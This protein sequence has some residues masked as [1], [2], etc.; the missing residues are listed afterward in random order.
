MIFF[1]PWYFNGFI[2]GEKVVT[3]FALGHVAS[4]VVFFVHETRKGFSTIRRGGREEENLR[5][6]MRVGNGDWLEEAWNSP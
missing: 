6:R 5:G 4:V 3:F 2:L 1:P